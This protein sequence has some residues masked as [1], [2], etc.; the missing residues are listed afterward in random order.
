M[1]TD[2]ARNAI[3]REPP[4]ILA[5]LL[6]Q[7]LSGRLLDAA[8]WQLIATSASLREHQPGRQ[9]RPGRDRGCERVIDRTLLP[10]PVTAGMYGSAGER[11]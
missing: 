10:L 1:I 9:A 8:T 5:V 4:P 11:Y 2:G 7:G 6:F 3:R